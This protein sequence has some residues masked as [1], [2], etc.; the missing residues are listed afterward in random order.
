MFL[1]FFF[2]FFSFMLSSP[3]QLSWPNIV[4]DFSLQPMFGFEETK[5]E[6]LKRKENPKLY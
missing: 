5:I 2:G 3:D 4:E 6:R 1:L